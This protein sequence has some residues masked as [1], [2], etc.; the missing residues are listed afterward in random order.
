MNLYY[1]FYRLP[2]V[3]W[4]IYPWTVFGFSDNELVV[5]VGICGTA[6]SGTIISP[7]CE[8]SLLALTSHS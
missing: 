5:V 3:D 6:V 4:I 1:K 8:N 7:A 2:F